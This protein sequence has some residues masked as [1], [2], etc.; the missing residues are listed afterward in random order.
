MKTALIIYGGWDGHAPKATADIFA[1]WLKEDG[2]TVSISDTLAALEKADAL[3]KLSLLVP[4][5][6]MGEITADQS[7]NACQAVADGVG[8]AGCHGGMCDA[9][10]KDVNWQFMTGGNWVAHPGND[11][12]PY[13]VNI[14]NSSSPIVEGIEELVGDK[15]GQHG[16]HGGTQATGQPE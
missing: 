10:R 6:T 16:K 12:T 7:R 13:R 14:R 5:W 4:I 11:G 9:F 15:Q 8:L 1:N 2:F 3:T